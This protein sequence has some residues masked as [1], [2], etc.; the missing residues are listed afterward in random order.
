M[1]NNVFQVKYMYRNLW[2]RDK[3]VHNMKSMVETKVDT[4]PK[5]H[6]RELRLSG[7]KSNQL[8][9]EKAI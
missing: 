1:I 3:T 8:K 2:T 6:A 5:L 7:I 9:G 4:A